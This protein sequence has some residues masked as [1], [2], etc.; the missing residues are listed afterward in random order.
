MRTL[1][2]TRD[3]TAGDLD[4]V[5]DVWR[6]E[7]VRIESRDGE[8]V[9]WVGGFRVGRSGCLADTLHLQDAQDTYGAI[10]ENDFECFF[11]PA[12]PSQGDV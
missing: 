6:S 2:L 10:P 8:D 7:P 4:L 1:W 12:S 11:V 3:R 5:V 9:T